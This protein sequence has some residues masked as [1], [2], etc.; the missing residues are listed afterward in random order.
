MRVKNRKDYCARRHFRRR[1]KLYGTGECPRLCVAVSNKHI[2]VEVVD[3]DSARTLASCSTAGATEKKDLTGAHT[4]GKRIAEQAL[5]IGVKTVVFDTG[6]HK[7][8]G[9][10]KAVSEGAREAGLKF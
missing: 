7:Y 4:L 8:H 9:R 2:Y 5:K 3:D 10:V 1:R 6:G